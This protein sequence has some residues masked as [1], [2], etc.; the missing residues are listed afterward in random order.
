MKKLLGIVALG[1]LLCGNVYAKT[2]NIED[3]ILLD[4]PENFSYIKLEAD[5]AADYYLSL[6]HI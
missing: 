6:I 3:K 1:L 5:E 2:I 4:V